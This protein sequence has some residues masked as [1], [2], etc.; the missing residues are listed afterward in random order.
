MSTKKRLLYPAPARRACCLS[1]A[2]KSF[3][4]PVIR[5]LLSLV[6]VLMSSACL[7]EAPTGIPTVISPTLIPTSTLPLPTP[8]PTRPAYQPGELVDYT[9]QMGDTLAALAARFNTTIPEIRTANPIIPDSATTMPTGLPMKIPIYYRPLWGSPYQIIPDS[10]YVNGPAQR[11]FDPVAWVDQQPGWLKNYV[12]SMADRNRRGGEIVQYIATIYSVSPRLLL[13]LTEY[14]THA[15]TN[16]D[17]PDPEDYY[18]LGKVSYTN[19][20]LYRQLIWA[21]DILNYGYYSWRSGSL[22]FFEHQDGR[23]ERPDPWQNAAT[24][25]LQYY[26]SRIMDGDA[27]QRAISGAGLAQTYQLLFGDPWVN[28]EP[29]I[30]G[31]LEQPAMRLPFEPG[32]AW[33]FTGGPHNAYGDEISPLSA[34]DFAPPAVIGGCQPSDQW[35]TAVADGVIARSWPAIAVLDLD[36][37]GDERTGWTVF[38]LHLASGS[39]PP[40]G[41]SLKAGDRIGRP[42]CEG[43]RS[44]GTHVHIARKYNGEWILAEGVL[45]FNLE[46]W[47]ARNGSA[48]YQG[49][50]YRTGRT[51]SACTCSDYSSQL[52]SMAPVTGP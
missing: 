48:P 25:S 51:I 5:L 12:A 17:P 29:H 33:A 15:L 45:G 31:S 30:P 14:Q 23:L 43:G 49:T 2:S 18:L 35:A 4:A 13:A 34:L 40:V 27:Y 47:I 37:D 3:H 6:L 32:P 21:A 16:P 44:T 28:L 38:Y 41:T 11:D 10:L 20:G 50:L 22:L 24:V 7:P 42:S 1:P 52:S 9:A 19:Q 26:Y 39:N 36:G 8:L 46:G